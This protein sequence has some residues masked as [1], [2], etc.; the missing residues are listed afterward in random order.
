[1]GDESGKRCCAAAKRAAA[2]SR[3]SD[4]LA[5]CRPNRPKK[6]TPGLPT[7]VLGAIVPAALAVEIGLLDFA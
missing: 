2:K 6:R 1:M 7:V 5:P 3:S 4:T